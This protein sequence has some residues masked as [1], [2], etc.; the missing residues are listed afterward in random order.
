MR[1]TGRSFLF[2][3]LFAC[4][5][6]LLGQGVATRTVK[7]QAKPKPSGRLFDAHFVDIAREAGLTLPVVYGEA[8]NKDYILEADG[9]GCAFIDYD[10]DGWIDIFLLSGTQMAGPPPDASN[11][12]Y[13]NNRDGTFY[14][15]NGKGR[16]A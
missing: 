13:K 2:T 11:R 16:P 14:R 5:A 9:C 12:L 8:D 4:S 6:R 7:P 1:I 10:N 3:S 15:G